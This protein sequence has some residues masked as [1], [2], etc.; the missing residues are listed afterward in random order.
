M[1]RVSAAK[2]E[3]YAQER[4]DIILNAAL[5]V[6]GR[7]NFSEAKMEQIAAA[8]GL[9]KGTLYLYFPTK[10]ALLQSLMERFSLLPELPEWVAAMGDISPLLGIPTLVAEM[11][12][13]LRERAELAKIVVREIHG[14]PERAKLFKEQVGLRTSR[15]LA[16]YLDLWMA[17]GV[18]RKQDPLATAQCLIGALWF[19]L[20]TQEVM[21]RKD[22]YPLS[23][24][25][26]TTTTAQMFLRGAVEIRPHSAESPSPR[27]T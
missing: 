14:N 21:G 27:R 17:R 24:E 18:L 9:S 13:R 23:D 1:A 4:R 15:S 12:Q 26:I 25:M 8:A 16:D 5:R 10:E 22:L 19:F 3:A 11:W 2:R 20:L 7:N 6:F